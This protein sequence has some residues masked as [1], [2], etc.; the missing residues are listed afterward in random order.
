[1]RELFRLVDDDLGQTVDALEATA[2]SMRTLD[3]TPERPVAREGWA[4]SDTQP[5]SVWALYARAADV[6]Q[7]R[8]QLAELRAYV[9]GETGGHVHAECY[10]RGRPG[11]GLE[12]VLALARAGSSTGSS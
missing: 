4:V 2:G 3:R 11:V 8:A 6:Q 10:D 9:D 7:V 5:G 1:M 12:A